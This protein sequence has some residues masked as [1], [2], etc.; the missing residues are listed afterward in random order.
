[1]K[2]N[3]GTKIIVLAVILVMII[4]IIV[5][6]VASTKLSTIKSSEVDKIVS[7]T[8][9]YNFALVY[10]APADD[11][12]IKDNKKSVKELTQEYTSVSDGKPLKAYYLDSNKIDEKAG[13]LSSVGEGATGY[14]FIVNNEIVKVVDEEL[15]NKQLRD[16][17]ELYSANTKE[18]SED[19][20]HFDTP[21]DAKEFTKLAK[22]KNKVYMFVFG[23]DSCFYCNQFKIVYNTVAEEYGVD[24]IYYIDSDSYDADEYDKI[25]DSGL[26][27]PAKCSDTKEE[28]VLQKG[29]GTP[30]TLFTKNGKTIDC[31]NGYSNKK[32]FITTLETVG[33]IKNED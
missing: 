11:D 18:I 23:R 26:K 25:M 1:M 3:M 21:T 8:S 28:V 29:F 12:N 7:N 2:K 22:D 17:I 20:I 15:S 33:M 14:G 10:M 6:K 4:P 9:N 31:I 19:L 27:I 13:V 32:N 24:G 16:Y 5:D 30:L